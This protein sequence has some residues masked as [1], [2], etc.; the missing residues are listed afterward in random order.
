M[1]LVSLNEN[2][3][4][5]N[6]PQ[7]IL[8]DKKKG[9]FSGRKIGGNKIGGKKGANFG[10]FDFG[11]IVGR[12]L[13]AK[14]HQI[15]DVV[16]DKLK[17]HDYD[18]NYDNIDSL[19]GDIDNKYDNENDDNKYDNENDNKYDNENDNKYDNENEDESDDVSDVNYNNKNDDNKDNNDMSIHPN[20]SSDSDTNYRD[21]STNTINK[22]G[23]IPCYNNNTKTDDSNE[24]NDMNIKTN[25]RKRIPKSK[26]E[27]KVKDV[28][29]ENS[30]FESYRIG[31]LACQSHLVSCDA[32]LGR[33]KKITGVQ[34]THMRV[35]IHEPEVLQK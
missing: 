22:N 35:V 29:S 30:D 23:Q 32:A 11:A 20:I 14:S 1:A 34:G 17:G 4:D 33:L 19:S 2:T 26:T 27:E 9:F 28:K 21:C 24:I 8:S 3:A 10:S 13:S 12:E 6:V 18:D 5:K 15:I 25:Q 31:F 7:L 16:E